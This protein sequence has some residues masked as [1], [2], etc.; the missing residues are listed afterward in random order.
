MAEGKHISIVALDGSNYPT[1]KI[2]CRMALIREGLWG[3]V[4]GTEAPP[5]QTT[6]AEKYKK[7]MGRRDKALATIVL[8]M[9]TSLLYLIG[10]P[11]DPAVVWEQLARQFQKKTWA[12]KLCLRKKL[13]S[14]RLSEG[15][16]M[17]DHVKSMTEIFREL[18][19]IAEPVSEEDQV[20]HLLASLPDSYDVLVT[21]MESGTDTVPPWETV[22]EKLLREE[23][24]LKGKGGDDEGKALAAKGNSDS[25]KHRFPCHYCGRPGHFKKDCR[26]LAQA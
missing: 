17:K 19:V 16:S 14:M 13:Y 21:A 6:E 26:K 8:A 20:V 24:K 15:G 23:Q 11:E 9:D 25:R 7:Y 1:W 10:D 22:T 2:Q 4:S 5:D 12:N 18:A 3:I